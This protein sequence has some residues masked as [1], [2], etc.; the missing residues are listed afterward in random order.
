[1]ARAK[2]ASA[3]PTAATAPVFPTRAA[4]VSGDA[5]QRNCANAVIRC[6]VEHPL[7][8]IARRCRRIQN[9]P[10]AAAGQRA[11][12][13]RRADDQA[14]CFFSK[15]DHRERPIQISV[16]HRLRAPPRAPYKPHR[17]SPSQDWSPAGAPCAPR[18]GTSHPGTDMAPRPGHTAGLV[19]TNSAVRRFH[20][21]AKLALV[22]PL[23]A[24]DAFSLG[25][26]SLLFH[27]ISLFQNSRLTP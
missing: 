11:A 24:A 25:N 6:A 12:H 9:Q 10:H 1:M 8:G 19:E 21:P 16:R 23:A 4:S 20:D 14:A 3:T 15:A 17:E 2:P 5:S 22:P 26:L 13:L 18:A 7:F 27:K